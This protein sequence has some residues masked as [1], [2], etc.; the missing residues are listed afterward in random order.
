MPRRWL[1]GLAATALLATGA[2]CGSDDADDERAVDDTTTSTTAD[3]WSNGDDPSPDTTASGE[4]VLDGELPPPGP[5]DIEP[6]YEE[7][8]AALGLQITSQGGL[9]DRSDGG[10]EPSSE[11]DHLAIYVAPME[12]YTAEQYIEGIRSV[13]IV[14]DDVF[15]R[16]PGLASYDVCQEPIPTADGRRQVPITQ[17]EL[18]RA[19]AEALDLEEMTVADIIRASRADPPGLA[20]RVNGSLANDPAYQAMLAD[21]GL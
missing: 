14:F 17:I 18:T 9:I 12:G 2:A 11:G 1:A 21:A 16:W 20:L 15:E 7:E 10:Y 6:L 13:A 8:L 3:G 5:F 19:E 4:V